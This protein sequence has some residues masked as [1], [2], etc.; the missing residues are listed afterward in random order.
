MMLIR[1]MS[2]HPLQLKEAYGQYRSDKVQGDET[3]ITTLDLRIMGNLAC[4]AG[5]GEILAMNWTVYWCV[6]III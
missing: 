3:K 5:D 2:I 1:L 6:Y 4:G